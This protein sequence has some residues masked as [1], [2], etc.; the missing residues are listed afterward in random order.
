MTMTTDEFAHTQ[1]S[2]TYKQLTAQHLSVQELRAALSQKGVF[3]TMSQ[4][5][6]DL[7]LYGYT[8]Y[9]ATHS[10]PP[11]EQPEQPEQPQQ[12]A[13]AAEEPKPSVPYQMG[14]SWLAGAIQR[15]Q[16]NAAA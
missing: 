11:A 2:G 9:A 3:R 10:Q 6:D 8:D 15:A 7:K 14:P 12:A 1:L 13:P 4:V 16:R 5:R